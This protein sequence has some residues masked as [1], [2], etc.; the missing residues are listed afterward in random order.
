[1]GVPEEGII[2][3]P[4]RT[5]PNVSLE[6]ALTEFQVPASQT[7]VTDVPSSPLGCFS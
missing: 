6:E 5:A 2:P 1:M 7:A 4:A 3:T